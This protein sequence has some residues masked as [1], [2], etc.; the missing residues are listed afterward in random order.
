[1]D[2]LKEYV[3]FHDWQIDSISASEE[4]RLILSLCFDGRQAEVTFEGTSRCVVEHFGMLNI[5]YDI[6]ILQP[7]DSQYKQAL[8]ILTKSDRFSKIPGEKIALVAATAGAE[9]V[10]EFNALEIKETVRTRE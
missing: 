2:N 1:M 10:V 5:V 9:I 7:D 8:S 6:T 4:N 3:F